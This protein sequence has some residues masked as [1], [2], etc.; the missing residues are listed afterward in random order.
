MS[1]KFGKKRFLIKIGN[2]SFKKILIVRIVLP[3]YLKC[4]QKLSFYQFFMV[5]SVVP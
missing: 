2:F 1:L 3:N 4:G 5:A